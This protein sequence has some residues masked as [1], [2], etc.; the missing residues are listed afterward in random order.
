FSLSPT[1]AS[2]TVGGGSGTVA[3]STAPD[4]AWTAQSNDAWIV[5]TAGFNGVGNGAVSYSVAANAGAPRTGTITVSGQTFT[6]SQAACQ[7][8]L[9]GPEKA[10]TSDGGSDAVAVHSF[11]GCAWSADKDVAWITI[12]SGQSGIG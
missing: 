11:S 12:D 5:I 9:G 4:C 8:S 2:S 10:F 7:L 1:S 3:V 6:I